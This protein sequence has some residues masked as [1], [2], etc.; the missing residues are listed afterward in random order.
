M[1]EM[2]RPFLLCT[3]LLSSVS[4]AHAQPELVSPGQQVL[5]ACANTY[6][7]LREFK[8]S[9]A[10]V[11][12]TSIESKTG[13]SSASPSSADA[14]FDFVRG[15][16]F[17][18]EGHDSSHDP[19]SIESTPQKTMTKWKPF[20]HD[21]NGIYPSIG[22][23]VAGFTGVAG[24]APST[25]PALLLES[26]WKYPF[27]LKAEATIKA[28]ET[29]GGQLCFVVVQKT[30]QRPGTRTLWI[31]AK[32]FLLRGM[33]EES[34]AYAF[35]IP[36]MTDKATKE[37]TPEQEVKVL[38]SNRMHVFSIDKTLPS[39]DELAATAKLNPNLPRIED[40]PKE[41]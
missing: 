25:V 10:V 18:I 7:S 3:A 23:A 14:S 40:Q 27:A 28:Q 30:Q 35:K 31:D 26:D 19:F 13:T 29:F 12:Q 11:S 1:P 9:A 5:R 39:E 4:L 21:E 41:N 15:E 24:L 37:T 16:H 34:G 17:N 38:F 8:G 6:K 36:A 33:R 22:S 32:T 2:R 20:G